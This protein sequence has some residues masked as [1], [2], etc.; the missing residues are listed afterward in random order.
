MDHWRGIALLGVFIQ[1][2]SI[3]FYTS[4]TANEDVLESLADDGTLISRNDLTNNGRKHAYTHTAWLCY[5]AL[6]VK[7]CELFLHDDL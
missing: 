4:I 2:L 6:G 3:R 1:R 5:E 7:S